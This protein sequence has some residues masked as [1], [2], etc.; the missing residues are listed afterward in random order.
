[1]SLYTEKF[2]QATH[3]KYD[4]GEGG[5]LAP[6]ATI[7]AP[8]VGNYVTVP[9]T[10]P[11]SG[12]YSLYFNDQST[13]AF[14]NKYLSYSTTAALTS[15]YP[16]SGAHIMWVYVPAVPQAVPLVVMDPDLGSRYMLRVLPG[17]TVVYVNSAGVEVAL[18]TPTVITLNAWHEFV[19]S[20][21]MLMTPVQ[22][23]SQVRIDN[24]DKGSITYNTA[25]D[26][27]LGSVGVRTGKVVADT[28]DQA[29]IDDVQFMPYTPIMPGPS[30]VGAESGTAF[31]PCP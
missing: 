9:T 2:A 11:H 8:W 25:V 21:S 31:V 17:G 12:S 26:G 13:T 27:Y 3:G 28:G 18:P 1:V 30:T 16:E 23:T 15:S 6:W 14:L 5:N 29:Y 7:S 22:G 24:N 19:F 20:F 10:Q 4:G